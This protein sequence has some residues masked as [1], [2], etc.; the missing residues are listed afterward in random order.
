MVT[1]EERVGFQLPSGQSNS[2]KIGATYSYGRALEG[3][4]G[5]I[6]ACMIHLEEQGKLDNKFETPF[7]RRKPW[8][9]PW[10]R[11]MPGAE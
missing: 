5:C 1:E 4:S 9:I 2:Y 8:R 11:V 3:A 6:R 7:R 10:P